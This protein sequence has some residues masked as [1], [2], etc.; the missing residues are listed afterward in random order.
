MIP[1][2]SDFVLSVAPRFSGTRAEAQLRIVG[3]I[4]AIFS[5]ILTKYQ[6]AHCTLYGASN[7]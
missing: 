3:E 1:V 5:S 6:V 2:D 4:S 7:P